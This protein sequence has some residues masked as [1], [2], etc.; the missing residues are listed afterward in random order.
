MSSSLQVAP[1]PS[2]FQAPEGLRHQKADAV[3]PETGDD[4]SIVQIMPRIVACVPGVQDLT[5]RRWCRA[6]VSQHQSRVKPSLRNAMSVAAQRTKTVRDA[7][8]MSPASARPERSPGRV[9]KIIVI[10]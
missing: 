2:S 1:A 7:G 8:D 5:S 6:R 10:S 9:L 4:R 3:M